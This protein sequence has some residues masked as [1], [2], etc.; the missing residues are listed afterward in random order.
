MRHT[1][2]ILVG[3]FATYAIVSACSGTHSVHSAEADGAAGAGAEEPRTML[4]IDCAPGQPHVTIDNGGELQAPVVND[5]FYTSP[6]CE[7]T[8]EPWW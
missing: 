1:L 6:G 4:T 5:T 2:K 8:T 7:I 3:S